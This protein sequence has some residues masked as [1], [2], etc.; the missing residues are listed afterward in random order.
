[1]DTNRI[2][3]CVLIAEDTRSNCKE[4]IHLIEGISIRTMIVES[5]DK[6]SISTSSFST[7]KIFNSVPSS[8]HLQNRLYVVFQ[9]SYRSGSP[10]LLFISTSDKP[11]HSVWHLTVILWGHPILE[12]WIIFFTRSYNSS[13]N[14]YRLFVIFIIKDRLLY[15]SRFVTFYFSDTL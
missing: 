10:V 12:R 4:V 5:N 9:E 13:V 2:P 6:F 14:S 8:R 15:L 7:W 1:M 11:K 3:V